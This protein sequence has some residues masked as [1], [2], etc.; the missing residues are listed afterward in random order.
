MFTCPVL[1]IISLVPSFSSCIS[2]HF[3]FSS[4][5][6]LFCKLD[7]FPVFLPH[8]LWII[9]LKT[10]S[11]YSSSSWATFIQPLVTTCLSCQSGSQLLKEEYT[12]CHFWLYSQTVYKQQPDKF[13]WQVMCL[14]TLNAKY[15]VMPDNHSLNIQGYLSMTAPLK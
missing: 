14:S 6:C 1:L 5:S 12:A 9:E 4:W 3:F 15:F 2:T 10:I 11:W 13:Q 8:V 7:V